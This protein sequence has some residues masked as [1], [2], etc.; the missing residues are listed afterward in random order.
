MLGIGG[1][2]KVLLALAL[3]QKA[4]GHKVK[5]LVY[6]Y[7][8]RW[9]PLFRG[10]GLEV[11]DDHQKAP[12]YDLKT[13][14]WILKNAKEADIVHTHDLNPA[15]Y[16]AP[17]KI[18]G[19]LRGK[20]FCHTTHGMENL[21]SRRIRLYE[22]FVAFCAD[23]IVCVGSSFAQF[24]R[25]Q[26]G[27]KRRKTAVIA[28]GV[29]P[30]VQKLGTASTKN[31]IC[32]EFGLD[33]HAPLAVFVG[34]I[35]KNKGQ[36]DLIRMYKGHSHQLLLI[37]PPAC[38]EY[39]QQCKEA[40]AKNMAMAGP[41]EDV[42]GLLA[43]CDYFVSASRH[44]GMPISA[45]EAGSA[46]LP[47]VLSDIPGHRQFNARRD[48][49]SLFN[50]AADLHKAVLDKKGM[51]KRALNFKRLIEKSYS[52]RKMALAYEDCYRS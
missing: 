6:D 32:S 42:A 28:N 13:M 18:A 33:P 16:V 43:A 17:L 31:K 41:R 22:T 50:G 15:M 39:Y 29:H 2:E 23:R 8:K 37:G 26:R 3:E 24:Y 20:I 14:R 27:V 36:L 7:D 4:L 40:L 49:V 1:L 5:I 52:A 45:L 9:V 21:S 44:E 47:C 35:G 46:G 30:V 10:M 19:L 34:R 12:G 51:R 38:K 11:N 48:C 25:N